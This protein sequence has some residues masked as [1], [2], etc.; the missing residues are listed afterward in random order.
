MGNFL[1]ADDITGIDSNTA[2]ELIGELETHLSL[3]YPLITT[4][5]GPAKLAQLTALLIPIIRRWEEMG[6]GVATQEATGPFVDRRSGKHVLWDHEKAA[7]RVLCGM[8]SGP[9]RSRGSFPEA[10]PI[11]GLFIRRPGWPTVGL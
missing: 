4:A 2:E 5:L 10:E 11:D 9:A 6:T 8:S 1:N 7:L 3:H